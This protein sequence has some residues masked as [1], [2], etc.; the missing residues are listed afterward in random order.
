[1]ASSNV[2]A[3]QNPILMILLS[4]NTI[5]MLGAGYFLY[6]SKLANLREP[7]IK[8]YELGSELDQADGTLKA[9]QG[10]PVPM[11]YFLV[12]LAENNGQNL[13]KVQMEF[14]VDSVGMQEEISK[15]MPQVRDT[16]ILLI[17]SKSYGQ[18]STPK[19][20]ERLKEELRT[21]LNSILHKGKIN[22]VFF[23]HFIYT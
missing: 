19:G 17:S 7:T 5:T 10:F 4:L 14:D 21:M 12:N 6:S 13:F 8:A 9:S 22:K 20:K 18:I 23:T 2:V 3:K 1:M 16:I 11:D 15:R